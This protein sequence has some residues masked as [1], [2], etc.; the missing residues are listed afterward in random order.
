[1]RIL[2]RNQIKLLAIVLMTVN[3]A[4][5]VFLPEGSILQTVM[6][7]AGYFTAPVMCALLVDGCHYTRDPGR[8]L[9]RLLFF[10]ALSQI[11]YMQALHLENGNVL[12]TL[13]LC[14]LAVHVMNTEGMRDRQALYLGGIVLLSLFCDWAGFLPAAAVLFEKSRG[15]QK[16]R[17]R[18]WAAFVILFGIMIA[19]D[20]T[21]AGNNA[22]KACLYGAGA[23]A[24]PAAAALCMLFLYNE[25]A[26]VRRDSFSKW[27]F[28]IYYPLHL[29]V[30]WLLRDY[31]F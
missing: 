4:A 13:A 2:N 11:P 18:A 6:I 19:T 3:H 27:F 30:L 23:A 10:A 5:W 17:Q 21:A 26:P 16:K 12:L 8:Y 1:M 24:G 15:D 20:M 7:D 29:T 31:M 25:N 28:Y 9:G 22:V 14:F